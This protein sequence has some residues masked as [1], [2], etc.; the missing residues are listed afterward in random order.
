[1]SKKIVLALLLVVAIGAVIFVVRARAAQRRAN[2][3][4]CAGRM[5][6]L[7]FVALMW[8]NDT[9]TNRFPASLMYLSNEVSPRW[10]I[11]P[12]DHSRHCATDWT[13]FTPDNS[14]YELV[15]PAIAPGLPPECGDDPAPVSLR[16]VLAAP[17]SSLFASS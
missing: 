10:L 11:C 3:Q 13:A 8:M 14:S 15:S 17:D 9:E 16:P 4:I 5:F 12:A 6:P 1:M 7:T 2:S